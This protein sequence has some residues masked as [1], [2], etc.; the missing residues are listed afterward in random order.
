MSA[1]SFS[2]ICL[3]YAGS[4]AGFYR[5][6][7]ALRSHGIQVVPLQLPGREELFLD[8]PYEDVAEAAK[9]LAPKVVDLVGRQA[10]F[11]LFGHSLGAVLA[12]ELAREVEL[13]GGTRLSHLFVSGSPGPWDGRAE[14]ATG[15]DDDEFVRRIGEFAGYRHEAFD[16]P[17]LRE[18]LLPLLRTDV[19]MHENYKPASDEPLSVPVTSL[20]GAD[21]VLVSR[22]QAHGWNASTTGRFTY[23]EV[24]GSH[25]YL[26]DSPQSV[27][28]AVS[29]ELSG[30]EAEPSGTESGTSDTLAG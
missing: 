5:P 28:D 26:V 19:A 25:M 8:E 18:L 23:R 3:P 16:D 30:T 1:A 22:E 17:D 27:L 29:A 10:P 20:R 6:W 7:N 12:Y 13:L 2:L 24:P 14:R 9:A 21:D 4:G 11:G 15:M